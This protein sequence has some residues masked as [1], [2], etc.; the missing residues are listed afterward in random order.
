MSSLE[1]TL[2]WLK[3]TWER[4]LFDGEKVP[5][6]VRTWKAFFKTLESYFL[7]SIGS[8]Q[9]LATLMFKEWEKEAGW[10]P[11]APVSPAVAIELAASGDKTLLALPASTRRAM[12]RYF[13]RH[14]ESMENLFLAVGARE[15][16]PIPPDAEEKPPT[17]DEME[18]RIRERK[19]SKARRLFGIFQRVVFALSAAFLILKQSFARRPVASLI[20]A[21]VLVAGIGAGV[22]VAGKGG[23]SSAANPE[24]ALFRFALEKGLSIQIEKLGTVEIGQ[25]AGIERRAER[26]LVSLAVSNMEGK[27]AIVDGAFRV[28]QVP[29]GSTAATLDQEFRNVFK[30][31]ENGQLVVAD[32]A[33]QPSVRGVPSFPE[34]KVRLGGAWSMPC[35]IW[36]YDVKPPFRVATEARYTWL[37]NSGKGDD[38]LAVIEIAYGARQVVPG[39]EAIA[40]L[41]LSNRGTLWWHP[42]EGRPVRYV[43]RHDE[44]WYMADGKKIA[45]GMEFTSTYTVART[46]ARK[47]QDAVKRDFQ[48]A[49]AKSSNAE[50]FIDAEGVTVRLKDILFPYNSAKLAAESMRILDSLRPVLERYPHYDIRV[51]GHADST[52][53]AGYNERLSLERAKAVTEYLAKGGGLPRLFAQGFGATRPVGDNSRDEGRRKNRR[54]E[55]TLRQ[56]G[57]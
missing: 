39:R 15:A 37:S 6:A 17:W 56:P 26:N 50:A 38:T 36:Y 22:V 32:G 10:P 2:L 23:A 20:A 53:Q 7:V 18:R 45:F 51:S 48:A 44:L 19:R 40:A 14:S 47:E 43:E 33:S 55:I 41:H 49:I 8:T 29:A 5:G 11:E 34:G 31:E 9:A 27:A 1:K 3:D 16:A 46:L 54:V 35:E 42:R 21:G 12:G 13:L 28:I 57:S 52:G 25:A 4:G 24:G 30:M